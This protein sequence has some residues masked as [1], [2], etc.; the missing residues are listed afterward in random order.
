MC[1]PHVAGLDGTLYD[2]YGGMDDLANKRVQF[3]GDAACRIQED[4]LRI[5]RYFRCSDFNRFLKLSYFNLVF[6]D[7]ELHMKPAVS[8]RV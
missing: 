1:Y 3:V 6:S 7:F 4:Y 5:L 2:Y 8:W